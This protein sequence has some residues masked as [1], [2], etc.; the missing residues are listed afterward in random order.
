MKPFAKAKRKIYAAKRKAVDK[1]LWEMERQSLIRVVADRI[2]LAKLL[3]H[4]TNYF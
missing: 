4:Y 3:D 1:V 2:A